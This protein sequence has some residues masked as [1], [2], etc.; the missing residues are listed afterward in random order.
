MSFEGFF[1]TA[2]GQRPYAYQTR[3]AEQPWPEALIAPT[4][5]GKTAAV[6]LS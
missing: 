1:K 5:L 4:G 6:I 2:T 3:L